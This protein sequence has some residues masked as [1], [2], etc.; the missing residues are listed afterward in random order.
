MLQNIEIEGSDVKLK[1]KGAK[2][3]RI[4]LFLNKLEIVIKNLNQ[5]KEI[6]GYVYDNTE[7]ENEF[8]EKVK[9]LE[10]IKEVISYYGENFVLDL[11]R[12]PEKNGVKITLRKPIQKCS[13]NEESQ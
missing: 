12:I 3:T 9:G 10:E 2:L 4:D 13:D 8:V 11:S 7:N 6:Y 1:V 5:H